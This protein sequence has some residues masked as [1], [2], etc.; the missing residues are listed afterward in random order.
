MDN[1]QLQESDTANTLRVVFAVISFF[2]IGIFVN[3][4]ALGMTFLNSQF[5]RGAF[6]NV[7]M[8]ELIREELDISAKDFINVDSIDISIAGDEMSGEFIDLVLDEVMDI[9][10][11]GD[12]KIDRDRFDEFFD[13]NE[14][15]I[16]KGT[17]PPPE[18]IE[19]AKNEL[20][21]MFEDKLKEYKKEFRSSDTYEVIHVFD[22]WKS[23]NITAM[24]ITGVITLLMVVSLVLIHKNKFRPMRSMGIA[25]T[26]I[27]ACNTV[28][29][30]LIYL[31]F[32]L[33]MNAAKKEQ[34]LIQV[35]V[36]RLHNSVGFVTLAMF[37]L[38]LVGIGLI[39]GGNIGIKRVNNVNDDWEGRYY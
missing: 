2:T 24:I 26:V 12:T 36:G 20:I 35:F 13:K 16:F 27:Q 31:L 11:D 1:R 9:F 23:G 6:V 38:L 15:V 21:D 3:C 34:E 17:N 7:D 29:W 10:L 18:V 39:V 28:L 5:W 4:A 22:E 30:L 33:L 37:L 19:K 14:G 25:L 32:N 8:R